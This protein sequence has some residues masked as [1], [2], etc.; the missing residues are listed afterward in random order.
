MAGQAFPPV[1]CVGNKADL[2]EQS[3]GGW[4][5]KG[6]GGGGQ[7]GGGGD[8]M[9]SGGDEVSGCAKAGKADGGIVHRIDAFIDRCAWHA[10]S[11]CGIQ[12]L[13]LF[14]AQVGCFQCRV[15]RVLPPGSESA[16]SINQET[17]RTQET[18]G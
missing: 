9:E 14:T 1:L 16:L 5:G 18:R 12:G 4:R 8:E 3:S 17:F 15:R 6:A 10:L 7:W 13:V 2:V 11:G